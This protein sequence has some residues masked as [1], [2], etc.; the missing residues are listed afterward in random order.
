MDVPMN[1]TSE[2]GTSF[3]K[4]TAERAVRAVAALLEPRRNGWPEITACEPPHAP[5]R[6]LTST[7]GNKRSP[8]PLPDCGCPSSRDTHQRARPPLAPSHFHPTED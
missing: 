5:A 8:H 6:E 2:V 7:S 4:E 1:L 3:V